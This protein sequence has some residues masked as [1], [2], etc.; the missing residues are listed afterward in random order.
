MIRF[1]NGF[2]KAPSS[3]EAIWGVFGFFEVI[4]PHRD[5]K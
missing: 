4:K 1:R 5:P 3:S 2:G